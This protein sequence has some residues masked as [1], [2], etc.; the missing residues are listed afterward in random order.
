YV[1][2]KKAS[3]CI[4]ALKTERTRKIYDEG[5]MPPDTFKNILDLYFGGDMEA[6]VGLAGQTSG[7]IDEVKPVAEIIETM[8]GEFHDITGKMGRLAAD[9]SF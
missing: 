6:S 9:R 7:L 8:V 3:P 1:L 2:N 4:R 5:L